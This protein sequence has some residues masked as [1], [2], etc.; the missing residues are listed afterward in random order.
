[1]NIKVIEDSTVRV[2]ITVIYSGGHTKVWENLK[3]KEN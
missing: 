2:V 3:N 1:M